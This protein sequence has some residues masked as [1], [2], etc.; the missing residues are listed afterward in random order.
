MIKPSVP[1]RAVTETREL[2]SHLEEKTV[3]K[4]IHKFE[5]NV[6]IPNQWPFHPQTV[7]Q[8][9]KNVT[10]KKLA[11]QIGGPCQQLHI[12]LFQNVTS[13]DQKTSR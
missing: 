13:A 5:V 3:K 4:T 2:F 9:H 11:Y 1:V 7:G 6:P 8:R 10:K 12:K